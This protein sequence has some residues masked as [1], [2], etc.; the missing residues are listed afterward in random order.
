VN[1]ANNVVAE[2][3]LFHLAV[4][5]AD[6]GAVALPVPPVLGTGPFGAPRAADA[7]LGV[8]RFGALRHAYTALV[9]AR[10][11]GTVPAIFVSASRPRLRESLAS[12]VDPKLLPLPG[13]AAERLVQREQYTLR[14]ALDGT[15]FADTAFPDSCVWLD[16]QQAVEGNLPA[17][18][19]SDEKVLTAGPVLL[20]DGAAP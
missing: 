16:T 14:V 5:G 9:A 10:P 17:T 19:F 3:A 13:P 6:G 4:A 11:D 2:V 7:P 18:A 12:R 1:A 8:S 15:C 20:F